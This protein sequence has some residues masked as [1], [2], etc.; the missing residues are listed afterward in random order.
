MQGGKEAK[1]PGSGKSARSARPFVLTEPGAHGLSIVAANKAATALGI[2]PG[3]S[4]TDARARLPRLVAEE[5][6][7]TADARALEALA[8]WMLRYT[9]LIALD[10]IDGLMLETTGCDHL[11]GGEAAMLARLCQK[12]DREGIGHRVGLAGTPG[13]AFAVAHGGGSQTPL[14]PETRKADL[15]RLPV[16][17]L[18][19]APGAVQLLRRFGLT[20]I[21]QLYDIDRK[22]LARRFA[23][24]DTAE[25]VMLRLDQALG[26]RLELLSPRQ[27]APDY[28]SRLPCPEPIGSSEAVKRGL[29]QLVYR[30]CAEL[31]DHGLGARAFTLRAFR[32]DGGLSSVSVSAARPQ[33]DPAHVLRLFAERVDRID[34][35]FG[36]DLLQLEAHRTG[37][38]SISA[39]ALSGDLAAN[40]HDEVALASLSDRITAR[41]GE[42]TVRIAL[43]QDSHLPECAETLAPFEGDLTDWAEAEKSPVSGPRPLR[44]LARA[45][46]VEVLAEVPDGPPIR[47]V[48]RRLARHV[49]R[50]DGPERIAPEWWQHERGS[51]NMPRPR[52]RDYYRVEDK[53]GR[54]Y[55]LYRDGLYDD[56]RGGPPTWFVQG[57]FA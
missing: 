25:A 7:R 52:A 36:I 21:G 39:I 53:T 40:D 1:H 2:G 55:W 20:R 23:S 30:L 33:R 12:L 15:A 28:V 37:P 14:T 56:G 8:D 24:R 50:A 51:K 35:G 38:M 13:A 45:E 54:R 49:A 29:E 57:F 4:F 19:L 31:S 27:P 34:P 10:G 44:L 46:P 3:L 42:G 16:A 41:L 6:D 9:P 47:F 43:P 32:G 17:A 18:R 22:A 48:W 11:H 5:I 26:Q